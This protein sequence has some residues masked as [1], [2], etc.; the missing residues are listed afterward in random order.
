MKLLHVSPWQGDHRGL[1][2]QPTYYTIMRNGSSAPYN[3][4]LQRTV[5]R[6]YLVYLFNSHSTP[7][8]SPPKGEKTK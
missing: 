2:T 4:G 5:T 7:S 3:I 1:L 6:N 8:V